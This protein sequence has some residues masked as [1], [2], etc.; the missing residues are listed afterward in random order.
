[1]A[2]E[3]VNERWQAEM[4]PFFEGTGGHADEM[5]C[6]ISTRR[7][8]PNL[9]FTLSSLTGLVGVVDNLAGH[10]ELDEFLSPHD[11]PA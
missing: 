1:M 3:E 2:E 8:K 9:E 10:V 11:E 6:S 5:R 4:A 7:A